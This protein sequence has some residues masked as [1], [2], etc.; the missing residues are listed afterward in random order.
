ME[1]AFQALNIFFYV[2]HTVLT[3]FIVLGWIWRK[4]RKLNLALIALTGFS[5]TV[6][7]FWYGFGYCPCTDWHWRVRMH[8]GYFDMPRSY[9]KF[10]L[11]QATGLDAPAAWVDGVTVGIFV[12]AGVM[13]L[14]LNWQDGWGKTPK[15]NKGEER[16]SVDAV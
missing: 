15:K 12:C 16:P 1:L 6:L 8:L 13:S 9:I 3:L 10:L 5:W 14:W 7:G 4:T 11:D 2:F